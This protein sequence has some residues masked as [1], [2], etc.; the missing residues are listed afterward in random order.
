M[1]LVLLGFGTLGGSRGLGAWEFWGS[2]D[3]EDVERAWDSGSY[4]VGDFE[5]V[6]RA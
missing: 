1:R 5:D 2:C 4:G 3:F 6:E